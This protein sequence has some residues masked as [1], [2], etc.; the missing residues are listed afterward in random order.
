MHLHH[1]RQVNLPLL[2]TTMACGAGFLAEREAARPMVPRAGKECCSLRV[3]RARLRG[4]VGSAAFAAA[5]FDSGVD[6]AW[7]RE[8]IKDREGEEALRSARNGETG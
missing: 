7:V 1:R 4:G 2:H 3:R 6:T 5:R 8:R